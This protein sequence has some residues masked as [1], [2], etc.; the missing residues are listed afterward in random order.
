MVYAKVNGL[1]KTLSKLKNVGEVYKQKVQEVLQEGAE[2]IKEDA[3]FSMKEGNGKPS[4]P[5][6]VPNKQTHKL[7]E[8][9]RIRQAGTTIAVGSEVDYASWLEFGTSRMEARPWL[10]PAYMKN[11]DVIKTKLTRIR[12]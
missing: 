2:Q 9:I 6:E 4:S 10:K 12:Y 11:I 1:N 7:A 8:S 3:I 5:G